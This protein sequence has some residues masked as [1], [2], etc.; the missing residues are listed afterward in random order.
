MNA[1]T[2]TPMAPSAHR[3]AHRPGKPSKLDD[4]EVRAFVDARIENMTFQELTAACRERFGEDRAPHKSALHRYW[5]CRQAA[6]PAAEL[7]V[8]QAHRAVSGRLTLESLINRLAQGRIREGAVIPID[9][10][11]G[12]LR[13]AAALVIVR[14]SGTKMTDSGTHP[15]DGGN[16]AP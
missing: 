16:L 10:S 7:R 9:L 15:Q 6:A 5:Q 1:K 12:G 14:V 8:G 13:L 4:I 11:A 2:S 3:A